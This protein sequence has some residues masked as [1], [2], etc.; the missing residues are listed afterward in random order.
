MKGPQAP[1]NWSKGRCQTDTY[2]EF[3]SSKPARCCE[4]VAGFEGPLF[5][6]LDGRSEKTAARDAPDLSRWT[7]VRYSDLLIDVRN[8]PVATWLLDASR[9]D[10]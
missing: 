5:F 6:V 2:L 7:V 10:A 9:L 1:W 8:D 3:Y 4:H